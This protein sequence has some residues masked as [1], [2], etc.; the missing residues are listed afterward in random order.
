MNN[1]GHGD[2]DAACSLCDHEVKQNIN[3]SGKWLLIL[4]AVIT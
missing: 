1:I 4:V 3:K 2:R